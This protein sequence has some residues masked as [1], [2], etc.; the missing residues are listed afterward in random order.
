MNF[1]T[2]SLLFPLLPHLS[3]LALSLMT[4]SGANVDAQS[5]S[6]IMTWDIFLLPSQIRRREAV[7]GQLLQPAGLA[8]SP[9]WQEH[10]TGWFWT[11]QGGTLGKQETRHTS[12][13]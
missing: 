1:C 10:P 11:V 4:K 3:P 13:G 5:G 6:S 2:R 9:P 8:Q 7:L 12:G